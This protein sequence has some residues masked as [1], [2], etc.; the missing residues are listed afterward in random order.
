MKT[1]VTP[2]L[3]FLTGGGQ[4]AARIAGHDWRATPLGPIE[5]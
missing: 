5:G 3:T 1:T 2:S 4:M